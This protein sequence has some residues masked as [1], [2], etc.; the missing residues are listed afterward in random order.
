MNAKQVKA[1]ADLMRDA[2]PPK[3]MYDTDE[4]PRPELHVTLEVAQGADNGNTYEARFWT[5]FG[6]HSFPDSF[7]LR[8]DGTVYVYDSEKDESHKVTKIEW[9]LTLAGSPR[10]RTVLRA[11]IEESVLA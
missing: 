10:Y 3:Q 9:D 4:D 2:A 5:T 7:Y 8:D 11:I 6:L 1:L